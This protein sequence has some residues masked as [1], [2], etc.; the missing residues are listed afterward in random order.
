MQWAWGIILFVSP[1]YDQ[2]ECSGDTRLVFFLYPFMTRNI[3]GDD[4]KFVVWPLWLLFSLGSTLGL[5]IILALSSPE[6]AHDPITRQS[7]HSISDGNSA[8]TPVL[9]QFVSIAVQAIPSWK[10]RTNVF[11]FLGNLFSFILWC[12]FLACKCGL[13]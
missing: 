7:T 10:D 9:R 1:V 6:R 11:I 13:L 12:I 4:A 5:T 3:N 2:P 8:T